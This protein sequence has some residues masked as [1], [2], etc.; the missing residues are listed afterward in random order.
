MDDSG[1][2]KNLVP[3]KFEDLIT[4]EDF[5]EKLE[6][7]K[8]D[9]RLHSI[10]HMGAQTDTLTS[11]ANTMFQNNFYYTK[12]L[13]EF[14]DKNPDSCRI[15]YASSAATYGNPMNGLFIDNEYSLQLLRPLTEYA[16]S[17]HLIDLDN[18]RK[19]R[20][21]HIVGLKFFNVFGPN[22][23]HKGNMSSKIYRAYNDMI[24]GKQTEVY[25]PPSTDCKFK[26]ERDFIY[27]KDL[28]EIVL[29]FLHHKDYNGLFNVGS[30]KSYSWY[31]IINYVADVTLHHDP[32][33]QLTPIPTS[34]LPR[35]Q[36]YTCSNN[37]KLNDTWGSTVTFTPLKE[38]I[39]DYIENYLIGNEEPKV[40]K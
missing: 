5:I 34:L 26:M 28:V 19:N 25:F 32:T 14:H 7:H 33:I 13:L 40:L 8:F 27:I 24:K 1:K 17:K 11:D 10:I 3:L 2:W 20:F 23:Y 37:E 4:P 30:G 6:N 36:Y 16:Y 35:Y 9:E 31:D 18:H 39:K 21:N 12:R 22:E 29:F 38:S 15:I